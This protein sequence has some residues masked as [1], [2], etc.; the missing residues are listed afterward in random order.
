[1]PADSV[2]QLIE[3]LKNIRLQETE[4]LERLVQ[5]RRRESTDLGHVARFNE[6]DRVEINNAI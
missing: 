5:A 2:D 6:G 3:Q 4:V 1:M